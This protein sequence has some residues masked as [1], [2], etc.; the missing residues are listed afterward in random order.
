MVYAFI[1]NE[2]YTFEMASFQYTL[3]G[4]VRIIRIQNFIKICFFKDREH[5]FYRNDT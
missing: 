1:V 5:Y 3:L 2:K 4:E